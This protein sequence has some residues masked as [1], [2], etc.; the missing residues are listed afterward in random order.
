[1]PASIVHLVRHGEVENPRRIRYGRLPG[2]HLSERGRAQAARTAAHLA[3]ASDV[4]LYASPLERAVE[5]AEIIARRLQLD[6]IHR[7]ERLIEADTVFEGKPKIAPAYPWNWRFLWNPFRPSWGEP[8]DQIRARMLG[9][10]SDLRA[11]HPDRTVVAVSHQ[12]P[13]WIT[14][15]GLE[16]VSPPWRSRMRCELA[17]IHTLRFTGPGGAYSGYDYWAPD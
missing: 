14:R 16:Q 6:D 8:F 5:T 7:D 15:E 4:V 11:R 13:I 3:A 17:S 10:L 12:S 2:F 1:M 9:A